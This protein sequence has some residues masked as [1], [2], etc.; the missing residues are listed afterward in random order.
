MKEKDSLIYDLIFSEKTE[1]KINVADYVQ[2][3]YKYEDF[4]NEIRLILKKSKVTIHSTQVLI[5]DVSVVWQL[6]VSK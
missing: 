2:D 1:F 4:I 5:T 6:K 3:I